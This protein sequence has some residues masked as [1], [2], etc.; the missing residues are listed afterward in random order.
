VDIAQLRAPDLLVATAALAGNEDAQAYLEA[1]MRD[2]IRP[3]ILRTLGSD[4]VL[5]AEV[6]Q[7]TLVDVLFG[8]NEDKPAKL[9]KYSARGRLT[10]WVKTVARHTAIEHIQ[11]LKRVSTSL[12]EEIISEF[13]LETQILVKG[14]ASH[15]TVA[16][17]RAMNALSSRERTLLYMSLVEDVSIDG[18]GAFYGCSRATAARRINKAKAAVVKQTQDWFCSE[19]GASPTEFQSLLHILLAGFL[20]VSVER[21]LR[22]SPKAL[23][24]G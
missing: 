14:Y 5:A 2:A 21:I 10:A 12:I 6:T 20:D 11:E 15:V 19:T 4:A 22:E 9:S 23:A 3:I 8:R 16:I 17:K 18:I 24:S 13:D 1:L 7:C